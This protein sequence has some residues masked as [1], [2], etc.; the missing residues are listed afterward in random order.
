[1]HTLP[2]TS[3][4]PTLHDLQRLKLRAS[5]LDLV[6]H[7][8]HTPGRRHGR[9]T[10]FCCPFHADRSPSLGV[11]E[12][13]GRWYCF[14]CDAHGDILDWLCRF[15]NL[16]F[17]TAVR[18]LE[19]LSGTPHAVHSFSTPT[20]AK[21]LSLSAAP[22]DLPAPGAFDAGAALRK[23]GGEIVARCQDMLWGPKRGAAVRAL[24]YLQARRGLSPA[25]IRAWQLGFSPG[26]RMRGVYVPAG[27]ILPAIVRGQVCGLKIRRIDGLHLTCARCGHSITSV[28]CPACGE[29]GANRYT[30]AA[31]SD[32]SALFGIDLVQPL[33]ACSGAPRDL[34]LVEG[35]INAMIAWQACHDLVDVLSPGS[36]QRHHG[37]AAWD[38]YL[39][40]YRRWLVVMDDDAAGNAGACCWSK[41]SA[42]THRL[43]VPALR[44]SDKD[45]CDFHIHGGD[46]RAWLLSCLPDVPATT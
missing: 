17:G 25:T 43:Q 32:G 10:L 26:M 6:R 21:R 45:L 8:L 22:G 44:P 35:E 4:S 38:T 20:P 30:S 7:D 16:D 28:C 40:R 23:A 11:T 12:N 41:A 29:Y 34:L 37:A 39:L 24:D 42:S 5:L 2:P 13:N 14:G 46:V 36:A 18:E 3:T 9:W 1:M 31:G 19:R 27:V 15:H 33:P